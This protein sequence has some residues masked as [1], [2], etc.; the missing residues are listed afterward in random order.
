[1]QLKSKEYADSMS[2]DDV[3]GI[4][5]YDHTTNQMKFNIVNLF[6]LDIVIT[7]QS[8]NTW[9][10]DKWNVNSDY[11]QLY[12][13]IEISKAKKLIKW[14]S[15]LP[16]IIRTGGRV[17]PVFMYYTNSCTQHVQKDPTTVSAYS[18][19][20]RSGVQP[21]EYVQTNIKI[22]DMMPR[23]ILNIKM[24]EFP[25]LLHELSALKDKSTGMRI[26]PPETVEDYLCISQ[27]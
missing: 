25:M 5:S 21:L 3:K 20:P 27:K 23:W 15:F 14:P 7:V 9:R 8:L 26:A 12:S 1:M 13:A 17:V 10:P 11:R 19:S 6:R 4:V 16:W 22:R 24:N 2:T 18:I